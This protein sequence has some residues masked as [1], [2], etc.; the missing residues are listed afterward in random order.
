MDEETRQNLLKEQQ[1]M[2]S[3]MD[4]AFYSPCNSEIELVK[5]G[6]NIQVTF[7]NLQEYID[8]VIHNIFYDTINL[9]IDAF[10]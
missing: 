9:Q 2:V 1:Q 3:D 5:G 6:I 10:K 8:L 4:L 7:D